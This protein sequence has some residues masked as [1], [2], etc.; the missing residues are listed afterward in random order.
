[1]IQKNQIQFSSSEFEEWAFSQWLKDN[2]AEK[3]AGLAP[4]LCRCCPYRGTQVYCDQ[5]IQW[6]Q[7]EV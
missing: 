5:R 2:L 3:C 7:Q 4:A 6:F 1:M